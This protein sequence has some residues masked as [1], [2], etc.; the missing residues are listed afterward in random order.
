MDE[1]QALE[2]ITAALPATGDVTYESLSEQLRASG[3]GDAIRHFHRL[4]RSKK[5]AV[6][7]E[8]SDSGLVM[9]VGRQSA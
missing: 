6:R 9:Y 8:R 5:L 3:Q 4:R 2:A 7:T 1:N